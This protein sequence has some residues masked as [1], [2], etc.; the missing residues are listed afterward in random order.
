[1]CFTTQ[2]SKDATVLRNRFRV[3][4]SE[5]IDLFGGVV[6][7]FSFPRT[8]VIANSNT[9]MIQLYTWGLIPSWA[10]N[11]DIQKNTLNARIETVAEKPAFR[12]SV[13]NRC[14]VLV[15]GFYEWKWL[16]EKGKAKQKYLISVP[17]EQ[18]FALA[19]IW[20]AWVD[21]GTSEIM[22]TY[23]IVTTEA[24]DLMAEIHNTKKRMPVI[25]TPENEK[26]W[27]LGVD[28]RDFALCDFPL[29]ATEM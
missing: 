14:L 25:L 20:S 23:S 18:P 9:E 21:R 12:N 26:G 16:D 4:M 24:N 1:M 6:S 22:N 7:G 11:K 17:G 27:L 5:D 8:P 2:Q 29:V 13:K 28:V 10:K 15:D 3:A 19:G